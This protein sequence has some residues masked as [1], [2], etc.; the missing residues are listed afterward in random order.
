MIDDI[1]KMGS[2]ES[3]LK[4]VYLYCTAKPEIVEEGRIDILYCK[5]EYC[6]AFSIELIYL[7]NT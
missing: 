3:S 6:K 7:I 2:T 1:G 5:P 4:S